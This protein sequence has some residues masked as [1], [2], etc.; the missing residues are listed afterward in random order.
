MTWNWQQPEWPL[1]SW[2]ARRLSRAE[3]RFLLGAGVTLGAVDHLDDTDREHVHLVAMGEEAL[4]TSE[5]EGE[6][7]DRDSVQSSIR[8]Q[9]GLSA[10]GRRATPAEEGIAAMMVDLYRTWEEPLDGE[11]LCSWHAMLMGGREDLDK[12]GC[13]RTHGE[14]MQVVSGTVA[15]P[16]VHFEAPPSPRVPGE[17]DGFIDWFNKS[18]PTGSDP[19]PVLTRAGTAHLYFESIHPF[20]DGNGR[21]GRAISEKALAQGLGQPQLTSLSPTIL[22][23]R[24]SYYRELESGSKQTEISGWLAY[25]AGIALEAQQ[26]T[27]AQVEFL[28]DKTKLLDRLR[29]QLNPRQEA[30]LL[31]VLQEGPQ[32]FAG[33]LSAGNYVRIAKTSPATATRDLV[34]LVSKGAL[35]RTGERRHARY[36]LTIPLRPVSQITIDPVGNIVVAGETE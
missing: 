30:V 17:M 8:R 1:F 4:T 31:R 9:L 7:L 26:R 13:Y 35:E 18:A 27:R 16:R 11:V 19:L 10:D 23:R 25:F 15:K 21:I 2:S 3:D 34:D 6:S 20:E 33:G 24:R 22:V 5:I 32:G 28:I 14:P 12:V 29:D 36:H